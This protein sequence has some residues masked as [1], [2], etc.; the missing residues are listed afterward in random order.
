MSTFLIDVLMYIYQQLKRLQSALKFLFFQKLVLQLRLK[1]TFYKLVIRVLIVTP[2]Y[3]KTKT[4][5]YSEIFL[6]ID[7]YTLAC[8]S[9]KLTSYKNNVTI[10]KINQ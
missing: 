6:T 1:M 10:Q 7:I 3:A 4:F 2:N 9:K 5:K 8:Q